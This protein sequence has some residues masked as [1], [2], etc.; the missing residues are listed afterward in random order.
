LSISPI[1]VV[2]VVVVVVITNIVVCGEYCLLPLPP[3]SEM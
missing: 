2:V 1:V 3:A